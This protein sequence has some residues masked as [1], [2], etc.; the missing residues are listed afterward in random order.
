MAAIGIRCTLTMIIAI[1]GATKAKMVPF[2][3][4]NQQLRISNNSQLQG[5][6]IVHIK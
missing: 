5:I 4:D 3:D 2:S 1:I 6:C